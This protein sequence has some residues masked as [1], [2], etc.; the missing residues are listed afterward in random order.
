MSAPAL[1]LPR[2]AAEL[3]VAMA[4]PEAAFAAVTP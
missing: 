2:E 3:L 1:A 4:Y